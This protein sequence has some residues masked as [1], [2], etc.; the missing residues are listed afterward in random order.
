MDA[1]IKANRSRATRALCMD[2]KGFVDMTV[3]SSNSVGHSI[4]KR[5]DNLFDE[6]YREMSGS[7]N[8]LIQ[9]GDYKFS[10]LEKD[11]FAGL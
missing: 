8:T 5:F 11:D 1:K 3:L 10:D 4:E 9:S 7:L 6:C 2:G